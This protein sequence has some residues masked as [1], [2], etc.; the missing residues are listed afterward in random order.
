MTD[1]TTPAKAKRKPPVGKP[2][3]K[4]VSGNP[5]GRP[6]GIGEVEAAAREHT[7]D[8][9]ETLRLIMLACRTDAEGAVV[10]KIVDKT[11]VR[12]SGEAAVRLIER[13]HGKPTQPVSGSGF[14][15]LAQVAALLLED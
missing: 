3:P 9:I 14:D 8:A 1:E 6:K 4:G 11:L 12:A 5:T 2:W 10:D 15:A 7:T 13:G